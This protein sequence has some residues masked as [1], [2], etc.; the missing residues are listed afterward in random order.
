V[1]GPVNLFALLAQT[2]QRFPD[3]GAVY[4]GD[5][6]CCTWQELRDRALHLAGSIRQQCPTG[7]R[8]AIISENRPEIVELLFGIRAAECVAVPINYRL[9]PREMIQILEDAGVSQ[10]F[11]S[12]TIAANRRRIAALRWKAWKQKPIHAGWPLHPPRRHARI[13]RRWPGCSTPAA[14]RLAAHR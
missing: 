13:R 1:D 6:R 11:A 14:R 8:I 7:A 10:V 5:R 3:R 4:H 9:H 2:A 12:A